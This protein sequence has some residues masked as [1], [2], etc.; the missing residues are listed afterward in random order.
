[1]LNFFFFSKLKHIKFGFNIGIVCHTNIAIGNFSICS[2]EQ[3]NVGS[4]LRFHGAH[5]GKSIVA[6]RVNKNK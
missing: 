2:L 5:G 3:K 6:S 1:M 4:K